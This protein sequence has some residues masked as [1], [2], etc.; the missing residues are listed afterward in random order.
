MR[1]LGHGRY[2]LILCRNRGKT[3]LGEE[4][5]TR[6]VFEESVLRALPSDEN[7]SVTVVPHLYD[8]A[9]EGAV[10]HRLRSLDGHLLVLAWLPSRASYWLL[11]NAGVRGTRGKVRDEPREDST[12][13]AVSR[14]TSSDDSESI[15]CLDLR[16]YAG[17]DACV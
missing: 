16:Q 11:R 15:Q 10:V 13:G 6:R 12:G 7:L 2:H 5:S 8:L 4:D 17:P 3:L 1:R 14:G 9:A